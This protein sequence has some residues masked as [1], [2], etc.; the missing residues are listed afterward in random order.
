M[1]IF[2]YYICL[3]ISL[4]VL[5]QAQNSS[6]ILHCAYENQGEEKERIFEEWIQEKQAETHL[7]IRNE[8]LKTI[9]VI[10]HII[11]YGEEVGQGTNLSSE[12]IKAQLNQV[13]NDLRRKEGTSGYNTHDFSEDMNIQLAPALI[14]ETYEPLEEAGINRINAIERG[15]TTTADGF[16]RSFIKDTILPHTQWNPETYFNVWIIDISSSILGFA[17]FPTV[18]EL[19]DLTETRIAERDGVVLHYKTVG[20]T[21]APNPQAIGNSFEPHSYGRTLTHELGHWL[22][23]RHTWGEGGCNSDDYCTDTPNS[24]GANYGCPSQAYSCS[25]FDL[26]ENYMDYT[27]DL[28]KNTFT[29]QQIHRAKTVL[30]NAPRRASLLYSKKSTPPVSAGM[31]EYKTQVIGRKIKVSWTTMF[32]NN[33]SYFEL[34]KSIDGHS[35]RRVAVVN[36]AVNADETTNYIQWDKTPH[37]GTNYYKLFQIDRDGYVKEIGVRKEN[38][39]K[40][41]DVNISPIPSKGDL[42]IVIHSEIADIAH[43]HLLDFSNR[44]VHHITK[45]LTIGENEVDLDMHK[46]P[47][48]VY[49]LR[50]SCGRWLKYIKVQK[51]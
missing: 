31:G 19:P 45:L 51:N 47:K 18:S 11:H 40:G 27:N 37:E 4:P 33:N 41:F 46:I 30:T 28:C 42:D 22:G 32:E 8:E 5:L 9:P 49:L 14:S 2:I 43:L 39:Y 15:F 35:Y 12:Q 17:E 23:L 25:S 34:Y 38:Y 21:V 6:P 16:S 1:K 29:K 13:N 3:S 7:G 50:V 36:S 20:S 24:S 48:G 10:F 44:Q 26:I